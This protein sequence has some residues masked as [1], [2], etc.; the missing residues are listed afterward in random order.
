MVLF[1][2]KNGNLE[3]V[4]QKNFNNEKELQSLI[5]TNINGIFNCHFLILEADNTHLMKEII[6]NIQ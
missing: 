2:N 1:L 3:I 6:S 4:Q 5:E